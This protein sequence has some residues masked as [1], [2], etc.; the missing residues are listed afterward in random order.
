MPRPKTKEQ[1]LKLSRKN[2]KKLN[3]LINSFPAEEQR[4]DFPEGTMNRNI[5]DVLAHLHHW[6]LMFLDW[7]YVGMK[8]EKPEMPATGYSWKSLPDLNKKIWE[9]YKDM[10]LEDALKLLE[11][12]FEEVQK[13]IQRHTEK[14]LFEKKHYRWTG[15][16]SLGAYL[17]S[18]TSSHYDWAYKLIKKAKKSSPFVT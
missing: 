17:V 8:D 2:Y 12:S 9:D 5:S 13:I 1:L 16:T 3:D 10:D 4:A 7:Y 18:A 15:S 11:E 14:E 6:H